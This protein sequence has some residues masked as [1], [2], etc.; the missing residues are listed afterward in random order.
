MPENLSVCLR[1]MQI[2]HHEA[3][4]AIPC[5]Q[6][7]VRGPV[8]TQR[9]LFFESETSMLKKAVSFARTICK[10]SAFNPWICHLPF[11]GMLGEG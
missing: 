7:F 6:D 11:E 3:E 9:N 5:V 2:A 1:G 10:G 8:Y 4:G